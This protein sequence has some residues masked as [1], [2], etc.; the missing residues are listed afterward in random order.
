MTVQPET[1]ERA[2]LAD[3]VL[4]WLAPRADE[5]EAL[6]KHLVNIDSNSFDKAGTDAVGEAVTEVLQADGIAV[7]RIPNEKFGDV[8][9]ADVPGTQQNSHALLLGHRDTVFA[10]GTVTTRGYSRE[11][12]LAYGPGVADMKG[13]LVV[14]IFALRAIKAVG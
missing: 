6:L 5:M 1:S 3:K 10:K 13:G 8:F 7:S 9:R 12:D 2:V 14:N 4:A 11:G